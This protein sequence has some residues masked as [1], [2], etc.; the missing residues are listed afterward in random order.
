MKKIFT[1]LFIV[2]GFYG[3]ASAQVKEK[4]TLNLA[5]L[6][7]L[8][9]HMLLPVT[10]AKILTRLRVSTPAFRE[11]FIFRTGGALK[12]KYCTTKKAGATVL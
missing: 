2:L 4:A 7:A 12:L 5:L 3:V 9:L 8:I 10:A 6:Q 11:I 1:T